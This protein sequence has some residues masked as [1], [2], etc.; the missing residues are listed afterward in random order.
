[1][2]GM[3]AHSDLLVRELVRA[4]HVPTLFATGDSA[5]DLRLHPVCPEG[6]QH[7]LPWEQWHGTPELAAWLRAAYARAWEAI[8][9]G[10]FDVVHNNTLSPDL[11]VWAQR[12]RIPVVT[13]LHVPPFEM[14]ATAVADHAVPWHRLTVPSRDQVGHWEVSAGNRLTVVPNGIDLQ[15]WPYNETMG[16]RAIWFGRITP[17]KGTAE[18]LR[19]ATAA[20]IGLDV[21]G[22]IDDADYYE[23]LRPLWGS[24]HR[25]VGHLAGADLAGAV[26]QARVA[27]CTPLWPEPFGLVAAEALACGTPVAALSRG[28]L[29]EVVGDCGATVPTAAELPSAIERALV[30]SRAACRSRAE[31]LFGAEAMVCAYLPVYAAAIAAAS[32][33]SSTSAELA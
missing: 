15:G 19:A 14:L 30:K 27:L 24:N 26:G 3:E 33:A 23:S 13:T 7:H 4:G 1:M 5:A 9:H 8:R 20:G 22:P 10:D 2:G 16:A 29:P 17:N 21:A 28:A 32:S 6:Y 25:Y 12:D 18:A 11:H 31:A